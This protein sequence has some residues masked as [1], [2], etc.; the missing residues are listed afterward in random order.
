M[1]DL[2]AQ[3]VVRCVCLPQPDKTVP[4]D[5][6]SPRSPPAA[7]TVAK[8][9]EAMASSR[10]HHAWPPPLPTVPELDAP[11]TESLMMLLT[12]LAWRRTPANKTWESRDNEC[13]D[14][15]YTPGTQSLRVRA[16]VHPHAD[17][18]A[19]R[20]R[21]CIIGSYVIILLLEKSTMPSRPASYSAYG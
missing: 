1:I 18:A 13:K 10:A 5:W 4:H 15:F 17:H 9:R 2:L 20:A 19:P 14:S 8:K 16:T 11:S 3:L 7:E 21:M 6:A 12:V